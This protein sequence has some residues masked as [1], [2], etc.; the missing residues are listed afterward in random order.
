MAPDLGG[1]PILPFSSLMAPLVAVEEYQM[2]EEEVAHWA[3]VGHLSLGAEG[4]LRCLEGGGGME[5]SPLV[6]PSILANDDIVS[7]NVRSH[8]GKATQYNESNV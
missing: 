2:V 3:G 7:G 6:K 1:L 8:S 4:V 5:R